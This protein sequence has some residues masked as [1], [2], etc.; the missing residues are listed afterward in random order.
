LGEKGESKNKSTTPRFLESWNGRN[1]AKSIPKFR[2]GGVGIV[3]QSEQG[4]WGK[5]LPFGEKG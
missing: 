1:G 4:L 3:E 5:V 2:G